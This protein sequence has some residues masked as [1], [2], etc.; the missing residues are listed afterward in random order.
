[1]YTKFSFRNLLEYLGVGTDVVKTDEISDA[2]SLSRPLSAEELAQLN[3]VVGELYGNFTAK[4]AEGRKLDAART[5]EVARGRVWSGVAAKAQG[6]VDDLGGL[7]RAVEIAREKVG[8]KPGEA[9]ELVPY[10]APS[11][12]SALSVS[13]SRSETSWAQA[14]GAELAGVPERWIPGLIRLSTR[15]GM[16]LFS[17]ILR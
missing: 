4:V 15:G 13:F 14:L 12:I 9:H 5:E 8:L 3:Q 10:P 17:P 7:G 2:L 6:L 1:V 11:L 16:M